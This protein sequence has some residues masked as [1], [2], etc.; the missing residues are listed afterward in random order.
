MKDFRENIFSGASMA[1]L[2][3]PTDKRKQ[4]QALESFFCKHAGSQ[5]KQLREELKIPQE[6]ISL[7]AGVD[8][9]TLSKV[10]R[11]GPQTISLKSFYALAAELDATVEIRILSRQEAIANIK[12]RD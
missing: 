3:L 10:E 9:S 4:L 8:Q 7:E 11:I 5:L 1:D 2:D 12:A 6:K